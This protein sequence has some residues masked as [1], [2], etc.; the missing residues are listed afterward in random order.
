MPFPGRSSDVIVLN[1]WAD[2]DIALT[3]RRGTLASG[4]QRKARYAIDIKSEP[5]LM[6]LDELNLGNVVAEAWAQRIRDQIQGIAVPASKATQAIRAK[7]VKALSDGA[8]WATKRYSGGRMGTLVP[9]SSDK[10]F[11]DS[12]RL[13]AGVSVR[14]NMTD[15]SYTV[16]L[17]ANRF[18]PDTFG[19]GYDKMV[20]R[21]MRLVP[22]INP[23][24][25]LGDEDIEK[26]IS[27]G[28]ASMIAKAEERSMAS[29]MRAQAKLRATKLR[30][31]KQVAGIARGA[32][33]L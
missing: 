28:V 7:A 12:G 2:G 15:S 23:K 3:E 16:N 30:L 22:I 10:L 9:N 31:L 1:T 5:L 8:A 26:A 14:A 29:I 27:Q 20:D 33:G 32:L 13:A 17:P 25:A 11:N 4:K 18:N 24:V 6:D 19:A 21:F